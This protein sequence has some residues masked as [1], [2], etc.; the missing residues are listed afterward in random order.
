M[1]NDAPAPVEFSVL[2]WNIGGLTE[3]DLQA[4]TQEVAKIIEAGQFS[5]VFLQE[6][7]PTTLCF[8]K[9]TLT[10]FRVLSAQVRLVQP[11]PKGDVGVYLW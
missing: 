9:K 1:S 5:I 2:S 3:Q 8:F 6:V 10:N 11:L 4:R 7:I